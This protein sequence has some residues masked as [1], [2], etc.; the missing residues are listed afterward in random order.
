MEQVGKDRTEQGGNG[1]MGLPEMSPEDMEQM[2]GLLG[3]LGENGDFQQYLDKIMQQ[4]M[5]KD[6]L[7]GPMRQ[8]DEKYKEFFTE[9][10]G[11]SPEDEAMYRKQH[12]YVR[13]ILAEYAKADCNTERVATLMQ[14]MQECGQPPPQ[15]TKELAGALGGEGLQNIPGLQG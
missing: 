1:G 7:E 12:D 8:I 11:M 15:I 3:G 10:P 14:E 5:S 13:E 6:V 2:K 4:M 9:N